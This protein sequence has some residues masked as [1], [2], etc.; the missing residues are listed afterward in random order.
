[1]AGS[2]YEDDYDAIGGER[3]FNHFYDPL[4]RNGLSNIPIDE[5]MQVGVT[6]FTW[7]SSFLS[8]LRFRGVLV[9]SR[10]REH[11]QSMVL[12]KCAG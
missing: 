2:Y 12:A 10:K 6:L 8:G 11:L 9:R 1:M 4:T 3:T 7:G 5:G